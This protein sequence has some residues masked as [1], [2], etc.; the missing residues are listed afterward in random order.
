MSKDVD[1]IQSEKSASTYWPHGNAS[2][3][4]KILMSNVL[5]RNLTK[6][7]LLGYSMGSELKDL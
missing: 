7:E 2:N 3:E 6:L 4:L 5:S 1:F